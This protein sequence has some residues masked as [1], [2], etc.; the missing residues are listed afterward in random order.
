MSRETGAGAA[1]RL[2]V[3][4]RAKLNLSL[5]VLG[6]RADGYH[7]MRM[8]MQSV[9][10]C[11]EVRLERREAGGVTLRSN[12]SFL[13]GDSRNI[14]VKAARV[15]FD[16]LGAAWP[17]LRIY[18]EKR[19]PVGAG[20][21]GGSADAAAVLRGLNAMSGAKLPPERLR[22]LAALVGSDVPFCVEGGTVLATGRGELLEPL[23]PLPDCGI[24]IC[25]P[26]FSIRTPELFGRIDARRSRIR[27]DTEGMVEALRAGDLPGIAQRMYNVF[28][29]VLPPH[30]EQ[31][32]VLRRALL[33]AGALGAVM[34]GTGS[35]V[36]GIFPDRAAAAA[37]R[38]ALRG[39]CRDCFA[40]WPEA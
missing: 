12:F 1:A 25:K 3:P 17:G 40:A 30:C 28:E 14:A 9:S 13:P 19:I 6:R 33:D 18:L 21:G 16:A 15:F 5:D 32:A 24:V 26:A 39:Q 4:A 8:V 7:A 31:I 11:D 27:P 2:S 34:S 20:L 23:P 10:L 35:A 29:D 22:E 36:F 37:A 38:D